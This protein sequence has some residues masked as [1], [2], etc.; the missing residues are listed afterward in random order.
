VVT[1]GLNSAVITGGGAMQLLPFQA[2]P[3][4]HE[5]VRLAVVTPLPPALCAVN[6]Q[7]TVPWKLAAAEF[8]PPAAGL[9]QPEAPFEQENETPPVALV[10]LQTTEYVWPKWTCEGL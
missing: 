8:E 6:V 4:G 7:L 3:A 9:S 5:E 2:V 10:E 1:E